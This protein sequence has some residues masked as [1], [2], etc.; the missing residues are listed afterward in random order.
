VH[1]NF[2]AISTKWSEMGSSNFNKPGTHGT[3]IQ[4]SSSMLAG[5]EFFKSNPGTNSKY[6]F[7]M[8]MKYI[9]TIV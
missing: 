3:K 5:Y 7:D 1:I 8:G 9:E 4:R 2:D 6:A